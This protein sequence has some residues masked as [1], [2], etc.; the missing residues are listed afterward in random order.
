MLL[1]SSRVGAVLVACLVLACQKSGE[2]PVRV[3]AASD[4]TPA[5][6]EVGREIER[7]SGRKTSFSFGSTGLLAKQIREGAPFDLFAAANE[8][9][10]DD[11]VGSGACDGSTKAIYGRGRIVVWSKK[12]GPTDLS[13]L[14]EARFDR[15][16]IANPEHAPYGRAAKQALEHA[17]I[18]SKVEP[19]LVL[20][21][22]VR[23]AL[24]FAETD[25]VSAAIVALSLVVGD[26]QGP[27]RLVD[28]GHHLPLSQALVVC[29]R[30][31]STAG[32][33][34]LASFIGSEPGRAILRRHGFLIPGESS[35][36]NR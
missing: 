10:V 33:R 16:A 26:R 6:T 25:N 27:W 19:R 21:E 15:I 23:Q 31:K 14:A 34:E 32:G 35:D 3:A 17:G 5:F 4:L 30:G 7:I 2:D 36:L 12:H 24:Q 1:K 28:E 8:S 13:S 18:W 9:F 20:G 22:N 29:T 11:V